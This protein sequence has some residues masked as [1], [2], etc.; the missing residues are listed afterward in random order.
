MNYPKPPRLPT[1]FQKGSNV[2][3]GEFV[4]TNGNSLGIISFDSSIFKKLAEK[5]FDRT[6][7]LINNFS[8]RENQIALKMQL[9]E[10]ILN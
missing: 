3:G 9:A 4:I 1:V 5:D 8:R 6:M 2:K 10:G 7:N